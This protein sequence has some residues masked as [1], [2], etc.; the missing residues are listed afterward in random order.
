MQRFCVLAGKAILGLAER[1]I[2]PAHRLGRLKPA[3]VHSD[4][5]P[6]AKARA[7]PESRR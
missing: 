3:T 2:A 6:L 7:L 1:D 5:S 4:L